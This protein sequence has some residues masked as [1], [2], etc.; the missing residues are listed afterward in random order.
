MVAGQ[1]SLNKVSALELDI[2]E[3]DDDRSLN[4]VD[5]CQRTA[6]HC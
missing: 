4:K 5:R 6:L 2:G 3:Y 1:S